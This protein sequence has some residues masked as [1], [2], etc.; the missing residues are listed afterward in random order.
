MTKSRYESGRG[1]RCSKTCQYRY[2]TRPKGLTYSVT[3]ENPTVFK[4]GDRPWNKDVAL[5]EKI[6]YRELHRWVARRK[7]KTGRCSRCDT[8]GL[9]DWANLS[10]E[11]R[12]DLDDWAELCRKCRKAHDADAGA[13]ATEIFGRKQVQNG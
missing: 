12:R 1:R 2:A 9:T 11:Y 6:T 3:K 13:P 7:D 10:H 8:P 5:K 4:P